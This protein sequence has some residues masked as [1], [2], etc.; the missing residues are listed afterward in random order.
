MT[1]PASLFS[2][3]AAD[4]TLARVRQI[5]GQ[6][7]PEGMTLEY[8]EAYSPGMVT[9]VAAI[10]NSY[11]GIILVGVTDQQRPDRLQGV[12]DTAMVQ[13]VNACHDRLEPPWEPEIIPVQLAPGGSR[14][15]LVLRID[16][17]P[18][19]RLHVGSYLWIEAFVTSLNSTADQPV[20]L[21]RIRPRR[22]LPAPAKSTSGNGMRANFRWQAS[23]L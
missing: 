13:I 8:K 12:P 22:V 19:R 15:I 9:T 4:V 23:K 10:A 17:S 16:R 1:S 7:L 6:N 14:Y 18:R 2:A 11:R 3:P 21:A 20:A 5:V